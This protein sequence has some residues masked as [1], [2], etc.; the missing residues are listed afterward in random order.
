[1]DVE[2]DGDGKTLCFRFPDR[3]LA[4]PNDKERVKV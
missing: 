2:A 3:E 1:V 4:A